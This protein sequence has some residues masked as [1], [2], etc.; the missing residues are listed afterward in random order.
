MRLNTLK[1]LKDDKCLEIINAN[2]LYKL[3]PVLN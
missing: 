1:E 2:G 3:S